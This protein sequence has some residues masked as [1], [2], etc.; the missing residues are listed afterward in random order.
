MIYKE[1]SFIESIVQ[2]FKRPDADELAQQELEESR[3]SLLECQRMK[4]YYDNMVKF[5]TARIA[6]LKKNSKQ[7]EDALGIH[8]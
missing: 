4:D 2:V 1:P 3:R 6:A 8:S 5:H 7:I